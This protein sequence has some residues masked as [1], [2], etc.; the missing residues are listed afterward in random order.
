MDG[1][2]F[3]KGHLNLQVRSF[4][5]APHSL[6]KSS[7]VED[8]KVTVRES[9]ASREERFLA[10]ALFQRQQDVMTSLAASSSLRNDLYC[11]GWGVKL[12]SNQI[13]PISIE[14]ADANSIKGEHTSKIVIRCVA[15]ASAGSLLSIK[16]I[17]V[18]DAVTGV[19][20]WHMRA[21]ASAAL[22]NWRLS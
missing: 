7:I 20:Q 12:Y 9:V 18:Y 5:Q 1:K 2:Y 4:A 10:A 3:L 13:Q 6:I 21:R 14:Q 16:S 8:E 15:S 19:G 22:G 17:R 11:V